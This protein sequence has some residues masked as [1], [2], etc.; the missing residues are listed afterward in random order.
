MG[1]AEPALWRIS[2]LYPLPYL[3]LR[4]RLSPGGENAEVEDDAE[5]G[6]EDGGGYFVGGVGMGKK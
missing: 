3:F 1:A 4:W 6:V 5:D 2:I